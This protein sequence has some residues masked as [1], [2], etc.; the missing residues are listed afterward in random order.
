MAKKDKKQ[1]ALSP[2]QIQ[3]GTQQSGA[4]AMQT[5]PVGQPVAQ[6]TTS[7]SSTTAQPTAV[8][9]TQPTATPVDD[10]LAARIAT[11]KAG[12]QVKRDAASAEREA[13]DEKAREALLAAQK[14]EA[15]ALRAYNQET[16]KNLG[17]IASKIETMQKEAKAND[18]TARRRENAMR[19]ISGLGDTLSSLAN[20]VSTA[21]GASNQNQTYNSHAVIQKAE[22]A[23]KARKLE[24]DDLSKRLDEMIARQMELKASGNLKEAEIAARQAKELAAQEA[25]ARKAAIEEN[26]YYDTLEK[27]AVTEATSA[28]K[29][30]QDVAHRDKV[31]T[32]NVRQFNE[33]QARLNKRSY[34]GGRGGNQPKEDKD[35][36]AIFKYV[37]DP[38]NQKKVVAANIRTIRDGFAQ[39]MGYKDYNEYLQYKEVS[40]WG[41]EIPGQRDRVSKRIRE[42]RKQ[43]HPDADKWLDALK[44]YD[45][46]SDEQLAELAEASSTYADALSGAAQRATGVK[47]KADDKSDKARETSTTN[48][49]EQY[50][51]K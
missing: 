16:W 45:M 6:T 47:P 9:P 7:D 35:N 31:F 19:Y 48:K 43:A 36:A 39:E 4:S 30:E 42:E 29:I 49:Y 28:Y 44:Y 5:S 14:G 41:E 18:E 51:R 26:R 17:E 33:N 10:S 32:E 3:E 21:H 13:A 20:L 38:K 23:R 34:G 25:A 50:A 1:D 37:S 22:E 8:T 12:I 15:E 24:I 2:E 27:S 46:L 11:A 40:G